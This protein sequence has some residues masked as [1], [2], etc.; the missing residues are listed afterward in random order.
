MEAMQAQARVSV[1]IPVYNVEKYLK[2]CLE[3]VLCQTYPFWE[4]ILVDDGL[5]DSSGRICE[6]Y[7]RRDRRFTVIHKE[8]KGVSAARN[9][10][11]EK[12]GTGGMS[13]FW[14]LMIA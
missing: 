4:C 11:L 3:S 1:I 5:T 12:V 9:T 6:E 8:N 14:T 13:A 10:G 7:S 2:E